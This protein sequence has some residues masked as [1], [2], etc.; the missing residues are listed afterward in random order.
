ML[1]Y[2]ILY[3]VNF[4][5]L[6]ANRLIDF[7]SVLLYFLFLSTFVIPIGH[8][9]YDIIIPRKISLNHFLTF[10]IK[11]FFAIFFIALWNMVFGISIVSNLVL[12]SIVY[13]YI[14]K[15]LI[16]ENYFYKQLAYCKNFK[17]SFLNFNKNNILS[18]VFILLISL[19]MTFFVSAS[20][21]IEQ[22]YESKVVLGVYASDLSQ[23]FAAINGIISANGTLLKGFDFMCVSGV[24]TLPFVYFPEVFQSVFLKLFNL[25]VIYFHG[26][27]FSE[28]VILIFIG[29]CFLPVYSNEN[30]KMKKGRE[31]L[32]GL[33]VLFM[34]SYEWGI[35]NCLSQAYTGSRSFLCW[36]C[37]LLAVQI[38]IFSKKQKSESFLSNN[39]YYLVFLLL[40]LSVSFHF[41]TGFFFLIAF[42]IF[43]FLSIL[44]Q[45]VK[46]SKL[47]YYF[48][49]FFIFMIVIC[50]DF[51]FTW[52]LAYEKENIKF[53]SNT[54]N[55][56]FLNSVWFRSA[57]GIN[58]FNHLFPINYIYEVFSSKG[59]GYNFFKVFACLIKILNIY[60][61]VIVFYFFSSIT[62]FKHFFAQIIIGSLIIVIFINFPY[63]SRPTML[64]EYI[65]RILF[66]TVTFMLLDILFVYKTFLT[67]NKKLKYIFAIFLI[68]SISLSCYR[69]Q[70]CAKTQKEISKEL[71]KTINFVKLNT[72]KNSVVMHD[73]NGGRL[74]AYISGYANR[75]TVLE[76]HA[77]KYVFPERTQ[78]DMRQKDLKT[79]YDSTTFTKEM[80]DILEKYGVDYLVIKN[81]KISV[82]LVQGFENL[83]SNQEYTILKVLKCHK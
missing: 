55:I 67:S 50:F 68:I 60:I 53:A 19:L 30:M 25:D 2:T 44:G 18:F 9:I 75:P 10:F 22:H 12:I 32:I 58:F 80:K 17:I 46:H 61:I 26:V 65:P 49:V 7:K 42:S 34:F 3:W 24:R 29:I 13:A 82:F 20:L 37:I 43:W 70:N 14:V 54:V 72:P 38:L 15:K 48:L 27:I 78:I 11:I 69:V 56:V 33:V 35:R 45:K 76:R 4:I 36:I 79:F 40:L 71:Y 6:I 31:I 8:C 52:P 28:F 62:R 77:Y 74:W 63:P 41:I 51:S 83:Y 1:F 57:A 81:D 21:V 47:I 66:L 39:N 16:K 5:Y 23:L 73:I 64:A 59:V